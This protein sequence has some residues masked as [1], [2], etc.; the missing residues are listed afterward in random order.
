MSPRTKEQYRDIREER[1]QQIMEA[2][3]EVF[4]EN[5]YHNSSISQIA[6]EANISKGLLYNYFHNKEELLVEV[7]SDSIQYLLRSFIEHTSE[8]AETQLRN[9][10]VNSFT[11]MD[12][13]YRHWRLYYSTIMQSG[14]QQIVMPKIMETAIPV[15]HNLAQLFKEMGYKEP[16]N[17]ARYFAAALGGLG[18]NYLMDAESFPKEYCI[19]RLCEIYK[20][21]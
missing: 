20:L 15:F 16:L 14:V 3:L 9:M 10:I 21:K 8:S 18:M 17:E 4:A 13:D 5:G 19:N 2:A 7:M 1:K 12:E 11:F 6:K